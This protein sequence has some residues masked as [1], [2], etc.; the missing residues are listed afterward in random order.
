MQTIMKQNSTFIL[1]SI[2]LAVPSTFHTIPSN[3]IKY[4]PTA[5]DRIHAYLFQKYAFRQ[6]HRLCVTPDKSR[7]YFLPGPRCP[8]RRGQEKSE[9]YEDIPG[10]CRVATLDEIRTH[11]HVLTPGRYVGSPDLEDDG[12]PF[13]EKMDRLML[14]LNRMFRESSI[15]EQRI[16][17]N[18]EGFPYDQ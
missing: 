1:N 10:Y 7:H 18:L 11:G 12:E 8:H 16:R 14:E 3:W 9:D 4:D 6:V 13:Y 2:S 15:L 17:T 5:Q